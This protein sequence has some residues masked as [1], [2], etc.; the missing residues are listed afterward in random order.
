MTG[1]R[2]LNNVWLQSG[3]SRFDYGDNII[4][5]QKLDAALY[6]I[7]EDKKKWTKYLNKVPIDNT[8][9]VDIGQSE[10]TEVYEMLYD[11]CKK[12]NIYREWKFKYKRGCLLYGVP[13]TGKSSIISKSIE[14]FIK[15]VDG[16]CFII[17]TKHELEWFSDF[18]TTVFREIEPDR[19]VMVIYED[20]DGIV[21]DNN[22]ETLLIN[23]LDGIGNYGNVFN[24]ATTN[25]TENLSDRLIKRPG[26]FDRKIEIKSPTYEVRLKF[27]TTKINEEYIKNIDINKWTKLSEGF[28]IAE[29]SELIKS[30]FLCNMS[31]EDSIDTI[32]SLS[33]KIIS[34][35]YNKE[36]KDSIGFK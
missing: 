1:N 33:K 27:F 34:T 22:A 12:K 10:A 14:Y 13:G 25:Y 4:V 5:K 16:V 19:M 17:K 15:E 20:I 9:T 35:Q 32:K 7:E 30:Y 23:M 28:T 2:N 31:L 24:I 3:N 21:G 11:F 8:M 29:L 6:I 18:F 26:R 36:I